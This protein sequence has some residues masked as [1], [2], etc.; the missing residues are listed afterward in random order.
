MS[1]LAV[2]F[3]ASGCVIV[4]YAFLKRKLPQFLLSAL[5]G[6]AAFFAADYLSSFFSFTLPLNAFTLAV[7]AVG[8]VPGVIL[9]NL[10][11]ALL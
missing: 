10:L 8:G 4:L 6:V 9:L 3:A 5:A 1:L 7:S 11:F 2:V